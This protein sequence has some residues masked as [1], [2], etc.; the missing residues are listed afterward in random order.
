MSIA[1]I[2]AGLAIREDL[3][4]LTFL[5]AKYQPGFILKSDLSTLARHF[6]KDIRTINKLLSDLVKSALIGQDQKAYYLRSWR[7]I[8]GRLQMNLQAFKATIAEI[9]DKDLFESKLLAAKV[10]S[11]QKT[12]RRR[13]EKAPVSEWG[14]THQRASSGILSKV[15]QVSNGKI[16]N[17]K[18][19]AVR[20][21][22]I[23]VEKSLEDYGPGTAESARILSR[24]M[25]GVFLKEGRL[26]RRQTD[27]IT[28]N[29][30]TFRIR[31]RRSRVRSGNSKCTQN[32]IKRGFS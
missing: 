17:L 24:E 19:K 9:R 32:H 5:K 31:N 23:T 10:T 15:C 26:K 14:F 1:S 16:S 4:L 30:E 18:R 22:F 11:L 7:F 12:F 2:P 13:K 20:K 3:R 8:T 21:G 29:I 27:Q 6:G 28:S 25:P